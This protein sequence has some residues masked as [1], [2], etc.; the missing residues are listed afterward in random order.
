VDRLHR[1]AALLLGRTHQAGTATDCNGNGILDEC[2]LLAGDA[3]DCNENGLPDS[4]D[5]AGGTSSDINQNG[6][7]DECEET[8]VPYRVEYGY[9]YM[10]RKIRRQLFE[11][12]AVGEE[13]DGPVM[14]TKYV[15]DGWRVIEELNGMDPVNPDATTRQYT[16][17]LDLAAQAGAVNS[18]EQAGGI[19]GLLA[20]RNTGAG[21]GLERSAIYFYDANGNVGQ[22]VTITAPYYGEIY[23]HY[24]YTPYG[25]VLVEPLFDQP[26][27]FSTK[28]FDSW[29]GLG[30]WGYRWYSPKLGRWVNRDPIGEKGGMSLYEYVKSAPTHR[31]DPAGLISPFPTLLIQGVSGPDLSLSGFNVTKAL[32]GCEPRVQDLIDWA[33]KMMREYARCGSERLLPTSLYVPY[34]APLYVFGWEIEDCV[35]ASLERQGIRTGVGGTTSPDGTIVVHPQGGQCG[36][37]E[38]HSNWIHETSHQSHVR[39][40]EKSYGVETPAYFAAYNSAWDWWTDEV[41]AYRSQIPFL[42]SVLSELK[43]VCCYPSSQPTP[44]SSPAT[45]GRGRESG[46]EPG[47]LGS[48]MI[49]AY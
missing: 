30:Y 28:P 20:L 41:R 8:L 27:R 10:G 3:L 11:W 46:C 7:P 22:V 4:C 43:R 44:T 33:R 40:L 26:Y 49:V 34:G 23:A 37:I 16:W 29:T 17:G 45:N 14:D 42:K 13:W 38:D 36:P 5:I 19:G 18:L 21:Y 24:E 15:Y 48:C 25:Q 47:A 35:D 12:D 31:W 2:E 32:C 9:D 6:T 1:V 39:D